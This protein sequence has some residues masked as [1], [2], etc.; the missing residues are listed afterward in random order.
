MEWFKNHSDTIVILSSFAFCFWILNEKINDI[1][2]DVA[3]IK[4]V[5]VMKNMMPAEL[6][7]SKD[8]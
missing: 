1:G 8:E 5:L 6:A 2:K 7:K 3:M 4:R